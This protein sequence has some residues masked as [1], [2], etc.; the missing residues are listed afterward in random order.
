[1]LHTNCDFVWLLIVSGWFLWWPP[2]HLPP[3]AI[4]SLYREGGEEGEGGRE[5]FILCLTLFNLSSL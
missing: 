2:T 3:Q 5:K 4:L 1:M